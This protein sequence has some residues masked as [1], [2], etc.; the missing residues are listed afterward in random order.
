MIT[1]IYVLVAYATDGR[2]IDLG[3]SED[4][5]QIQSEVTSD[6]TKAQLDELG[7]KDVSFKIRDNFFPTNYYPV[8]QQNNT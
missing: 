8:N 7:I 2:I 5:K 4:L 3:Y 6:D 1:K